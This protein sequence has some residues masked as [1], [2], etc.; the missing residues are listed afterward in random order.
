M[1]DSLTDEKSFQSLKIVELKG[2]AIE[3]RYQN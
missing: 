2:M 1:A 3:K